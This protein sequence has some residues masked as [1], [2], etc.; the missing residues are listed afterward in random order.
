MIHSAIDTQSALSPT[1]LLY[2]DICKWQTCLVVNSGPIKSEWKQHWWF[3][4]KIP[5]SFV[6]FSVRWK[7]KKKKINRKDSCF[8]YHEVFYSIWHDF[9]CEK[10]LEEMSSKWM[11]EWYSLNYLPGFSFKFWLILHDFL[12]VE[13]RNTCHLRYKHKLC[14]FAA[15]L[16]KVTGTSISLPF[17]EQDTSLFHIVPL[18]S[19]LSTLSIYISTLH[20]PPLPHP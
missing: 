6:K 16:L 8:W 5:T 9:I 12:S 11:N 4:S 3:N 19:P 14:S 17:R 7:W 18:M 1:P 2:H 10:F 13:Y 15:W 20:P